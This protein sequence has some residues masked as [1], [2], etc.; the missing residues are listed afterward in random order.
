MKTLS[1]LLAVT[2]L[3]LMG[4]AEAAPDPSKVPQPSVQDEYEPRIKTTVIELK[5]A[6]TK[7][8]VEMLLPNARILKVP[9]TRGYEA[10][11]INFKTGFNCTGLIPPFG[12]ANLTCGSEKRAYSLSRDPRTHQLKLELLTID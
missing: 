4:T 7:D 11:G 10:V 5:W 8:G 2:T 9:G 6:P 1:T 12:P 3:C